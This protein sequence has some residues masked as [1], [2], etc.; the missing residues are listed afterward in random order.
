VPVGEVCP[1][2]LPEVPPEPR[3]EVPLPGLSSPLSC[4]PSAAVPWA[5]L[6]VLKEPESSPSADPVW[7]QAW[8]PSSRPLPVQAQAPEAKVLGPAGG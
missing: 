1:G 5:V 6:P 2:V 4:P 7:A 8:R 3:S